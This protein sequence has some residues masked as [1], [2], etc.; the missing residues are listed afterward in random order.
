MTPGLVEHITNSHSHCIF[1]VLGNKSLLDTTTMA[2]GV[3]AGRDEGSGQYTN[4]LTNR[5]KLVPSHFGR[6][7]LVASDKGHLD[8]K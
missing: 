6:V 1:H 7:I 3:H 8:L 2:T 5:I 4:S